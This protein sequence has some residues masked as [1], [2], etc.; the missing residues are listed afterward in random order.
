M[1]RSNVDIASAFAQFDPGEYHKWRVGGEFFCAIESSTVMQRITA[2]PFERALDVGCGTGLWTG[3][4]H[5]VRPAA[6]VVGYDLDESMVDYA[7]VAHPRIRF[8]SCDAREFQDT[9]GFDVVIA[10]MSADYIGFGVLARA[11]EANMRSSGTAFVWFL[12]SSRYELRR[13]RRMKRWRVGDRL[14]E[15][16]IENYTMAE[17]VGAFEAHGLICVPS[18]KSFQLLDGRER[19]LVF[20]EARHDVS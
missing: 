12:D 13:G 5:S 19:T 20:V 7:T 4:L 14:V 2:E 8:E 11:I 18:F 17:V 6:E 9:A 3:I 10:A 15:V 16:D 1:I